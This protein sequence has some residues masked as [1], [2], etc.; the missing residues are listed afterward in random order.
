MTKR[1]SPRTIA[2]SS[3]IGSD[4]VF[5][6]VTPPIY[7]S[8]TYTFPAFNQKGE[9]DYSRG[10]NPTRSMFAQALADLEG[11]EAAIITASGLAA[12]DLVGLL[13]GPDDLIL[14]PH[15]C[16]GGSHRLL[17]ARAEKGHFRVRFVDQNDEQ[18][19]GAAFEEKPAWILIETPSNPLM[20]LV[21]IQKVAGTAK[22]AGARI[23]VDNTFL[24]PARQKPLRLGADLV[25]HSV[26]KYLNGHSDV[27]G[28]AL[29][30][31]D[32]VLGEELA[33]WANCVGSTGGAFDSYL[34][35][36]GLRTLYARMDAQEKS[37]LEI[38]SWLADH[39]MIKSV[40][41][42][43]LKTHPNYDLAQKQ[44]SGPGAMLS[45]ELKEGG[46]EV[47][48]VCEAFSLFS[49]AESLGGVE[50]LVSHPA[51]MTHAGMDEDARIAAGINNNLLRLSVGLEE[52]ADLIADLDRALRGG[53]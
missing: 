49:L 28:G 24:S 37:A 38:A 42:P 18:E 2:A 31:R 52:V 51:T 27:I 53:G 1:Q 8:S 29:I 11:G 45:F 16:Y 7:L 20:R 21:D 4:P 3:A 23:L 9:F 6:A 36:R 25:L 19:L 39:P 33:W 17:S 46:P 40:N 47:G 5:G 34:A 26:T 10:G 13:L 48:K 35:L 44:Q 41:Y 43:G 14:A 30:A 32:A 22:A 50:S 12:L 15:D